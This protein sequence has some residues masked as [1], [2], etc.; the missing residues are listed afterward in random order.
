MKRK[1]TSKTDSDKAYLRK[2]RAQFGPWLAALGM[3]GVLEALPG[4]WRRYL[5]S[6]KWR[7][8]EIAYDDPPSWWPGLRAQIEERWRQTFFEPFKEGESLSALEAL[9]V[10]W[11]MIYNLDAI[12]NHPTNHAV[13]ERFGPPPAPDM[14]VI[15]K[16]SNLLGQITAQGLTCVAR[17]DEAILRI[18]TIMGRP[19]QARE[20]VFQWRVTTTRAQADRAAHKGKER[21][22]YRVADPI[23]SAAVEWVEL[24]PSLLGLSQR[25]GR[26]PVY[27]QSHALVRLSERLRFWPGALPD[28]PFFHGIFQAGRADSM[29]QPR[30]VRQSGREFLVEYRVGLYN[31][32]YLAAELMG[33]K[34]V[35]KTF[36]LRGMQGTPEGEQLREKLK[37]SRGQ[38]EWLYLDHLE[39]WV[40]S[41][42]RQ[43]AEIRPLLEECGFADLL[44]CADQNCWETMTKVA[45]EFRKFVGEDHLKLARERLGLECTARAA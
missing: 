6:R 14:Q 37:L 40:N 35:V 1:R 17:I 20:P 4:F 15:I 29:R 34:V 42:L 22:I 19:D 11:P 12:L 30:I 21:P 18:Q 26:L 10:Y 27:V 41:D 24:D 39:Q 44:R 31:L 33:P 16:A 23:G 5:L 3:E 32:G 9:T 7:M 28:R 8:P 2:R 25:T 43:D 13:L 38:I 45:G 36:L